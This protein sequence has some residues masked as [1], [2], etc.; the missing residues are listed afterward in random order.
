[1]LTVGDWEMSK[2][3]GWHAM[4]SLQKMGQFS[5]PASPTLWENL[6]RQ[7][8]MTE[9]QALWEIRLFTQEGDKIRTWIRKH[10]T[11]KYV[12]EEALL[13]LRIPIWH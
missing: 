11:S 4:N 3:S 9:Q 2:Q 12:P 1:M 6:L 10:H 5:E 8:N 13:E 7:M